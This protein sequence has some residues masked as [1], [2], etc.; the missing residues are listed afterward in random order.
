MWIPLTDWAA[1]RHKRIPLH[2]LRRWAREGK[3]SPPARKV[4]REYQ[5]LDTA[6]HIEDFT[7]RPSLV[8]RLAR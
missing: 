7:L 1:V 3:I 6:E 8:E 4:G 2:T 5:V